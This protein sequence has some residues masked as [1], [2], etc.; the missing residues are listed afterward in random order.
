MEHRLTLL[1]GTPVPTADQTA[2]TTIYMTPYVGT[3]IS[4]YNGTAW[5]QYTSAEVSVSVPATTTTPFDVFAYDNGS[6]VVTI[7]AVTWTNTTTRATALVLQDG[8]LVK[9]GATGRR[10]IGTGLT[11]AVSGQCADSFAYRGV[12]NYY[13]RV[14]R[15]FMKNENS[16]TASW[17]YTTATYRAANGVSANKV[18]MVSC[19]ADQSIEIMVSSSSANSSAASRVVGIGEDSTSVDSS[20]INCGTGDASGALGNS[21][22]ILNKIPTAGYHAYTWLETSAAV[23]TTTWYGETTNVSSGISGY[24]MA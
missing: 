7:E 6:G 24:V 22:A 5:Q 18:E 4:L 1:T 2:K 10:F 23:G 20:Q 21:W 15:Y 14:P 11:T 9:S 13:N 3:R 8:V 16:N 12:S 19:N 17:T